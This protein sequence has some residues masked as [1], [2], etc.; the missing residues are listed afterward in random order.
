[1]SEAEKERR[2]R[3]E[4]EGMKGKRKKKKGRKDGRTGGSLVRG[5]D[6]AVEERLQGRM[7]AGSEY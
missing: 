5:K 2:R 3:G 4:A 6:I 1:M 7:L